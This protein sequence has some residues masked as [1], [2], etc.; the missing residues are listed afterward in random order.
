MRVNPYQLQQAL[1][2]QLAPIYLLS[3]DEPLQLGEAADSIRLAAKNAGYLNRE[4]FS[5]ETNFNW[6]Q[7]TTAADSFSIFSDKQLL[8]LKVPSGKFGIEGTKVITRYCQNPPEDSILLITSSKLASSSLKAKWYQAVDKVGVTLQ[9]WSLE[10]RDLLQWLQQ[11]LENR[12]LQIEP[13]AIKLLAS[14]IEGNLLAASQEIEKLYILYGA[15]RLSNQQV[16]KAVTDSSRFDVFN[17]TNALLQGNPNRCF[18]ILQGL[19]MEGIAAP[20]VLWALT[21]EIRQLISLK[22]ATHREQVF[23]KLRIWD[24]RKHLLNQALERFSL[25]DLEHSLVLS[26]E[27]DQQIKGQKKGDYWETLLAVCLLLSTNKNQR[28]FPT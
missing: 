20:V 16:E 1:N 6:N 21:R 24:K 5:A 15:G 14:R 8:D 4:V 9:V 11:R 12:G 18:K 22:T 17:L 7:I 25:K 23:K 2:R 27:A 13:D 10:G 28:V 26:A 3:G 19:K